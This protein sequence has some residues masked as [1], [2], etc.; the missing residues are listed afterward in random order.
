M[1]QSILT[2]LNLSSLNNNQQPLYKLLSCSFL[3][4]MQLQQ[5]IWTLY[6]KIFFWPFLMTQLLQNI[7]PQIANGL[8]IQMVF[9][10][11][12]TEFIYHLLIISIYISSSIIMITFLPDIMIKT[13]HQNYFTMDI[14]SPASILIYNN[15]ASP[16]SLVCDP[17]HNVTSPTDLSNN[18]LFLNDHGIPFLWTSSKNFCH[19]SGLTLSWSQLTSSPS[20]QSLS[21]PTT[22]SH[23]FFLHVFSKHSIP[24]H[25]I[26]DRGSEFVSNFF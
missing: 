8:W 21:L 9:S 13:K 3:F 11:F 20:R 14:P 4:S 1:P 5:L 24:S 17:S 16:M 12:T 6:I 22:L 25:V 7:S 15:S 10:F 2:T 18:F 26:S 23:L 19:P